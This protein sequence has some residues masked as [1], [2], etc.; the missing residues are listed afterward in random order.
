MGTTDTIVTAEPAGADD[1]PSWTLMYNVYQTLLSVPA[2]TSNIQ[3]DAANC[4]Y[5]D[6]KTYVCTLEPNQ[7]FSNG[8][9]VTGADVAYSFNRV[10]KI[11]SATGPSSLLAPMK[12]VTASGNTVT[13]KLRAVDATWPYVPQPARGVHAEP[14]LRRP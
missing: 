10:I 1:L 11:A 5:T 7:A 13:F 3:P 6:P 14:P 12:S 4:S 9:P 8:D 2:G